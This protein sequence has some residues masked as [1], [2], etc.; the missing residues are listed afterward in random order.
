MARARFLPCIF[1]ALRMH[2]ARFLAALDFFAATRFVT[3]MVL[4]ETFSTGTWTTCAGAGPG[5]GLRCDHAKSPP[6]P[7]CR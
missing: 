4:V 7:A 5:G 6:S 3:V 1:L 2:A